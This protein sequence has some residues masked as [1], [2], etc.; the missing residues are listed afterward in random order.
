LLGPPESSQP[1]SIP[2]AELEPV[3]VDPRRLEFVFRGGR[4]SLDFV[5]TLGSRGHFNIERLA[6]PEHLDRWLREAGLAA[7]GAP[8]DTKRLRRAIQLREAIHAA[9]RRGQQGAAPTAAIRTIN[10]CA[11][12]APLAPKLLADGHTMAWHADASLQAALSTL[13]RDAI[14]LLSSPLL[15]RVRQ[16]AGTPCTLLFLDTSR[17]GKRRWCSMDDCGNREKA[18]GLRTKRQAAKQARDNPIT[19][20]HA[21]R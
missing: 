7:T 12:H 8:A 1:A 19:E 3:T 21:S 11:A 14:E 18:A 15:T 2:G 10:R 9:I 5:N 17:P 20:T 13:A 16:C 4:L 6:A